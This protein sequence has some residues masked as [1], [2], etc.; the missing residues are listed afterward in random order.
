MSLSKYV[1]VFAFAFVLAL[2]YVFASV[3]VTR[4]TNVNNLRFGLFHTMY[5][6]LSDETWYTLTSVHGQLTACT[7]CDID[8]LVTVY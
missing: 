6:G 2:A 8:L 3:S 4:L 7:I 5:K 1:S